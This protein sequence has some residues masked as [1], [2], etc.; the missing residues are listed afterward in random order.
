MKVNPTTHRAAAIV[1]AGGQ[2]TRIRHLYPDLPKPMVPAAG[3][4]FLEWVLRWLGQQGVERSIV[5]LGHL[6]SVADD[7]LRGRPAD[8]LRIQTVREPRALGTGGAVAWAC[9]AID[10]EIIVVTNG[11]SLLLADLAPAWKLLNDTSIDGVVIGLEVDDAARYGRL[12]VTSD[13]RLLRFSEKQPGRGLINGGVYLL[14]R[15]LIDQ[16]PRQRPLSM[17]TDV[18][19]A[20]LAR[21]VRLAVKACRAPFLDIGT[22]ESVVEADRFIQQHFLT[23]KAAA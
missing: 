5:S 20:L 10:A 2:G 7:Y 19:P 12:Q 1:L 11:D 22:P 13:G 18:F 9:A 23:G 17:E 16:F 14:R 15:S 4:P 21:G 8:R 3:R 6:A